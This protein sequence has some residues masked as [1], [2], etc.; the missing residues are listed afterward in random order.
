MAR[1]TFTKP[2]ETYD[3]NYF[4]NLIN[5]IES[6]T[7]LNFNKGE[8]IEANGFDGTEIV[9]VSPN[10]TKYKLTVDDSGTIGTTQVV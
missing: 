5:D 4:S 1:K 10:G 3:Q 8:R 9:L 2:R 7:A 6:S